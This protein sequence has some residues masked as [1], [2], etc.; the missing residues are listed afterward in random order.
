[1]GSKIFEK[2]Q[3]SKN[4]S[5]LIFNK[6]DSFIHKHD[7]LYIIIPYYCFIY[8]KENE[9]NLINF[10]EKYH[11]N[12]NAS[13]YLIEGL[14]N[15]VKSLKLSEKYDITHIKITIKDVLYVRENLINIAINN[16]PSDWNYLA[17]I[18]YNIFFTNNDWIIDTIN[19]LDLYDVVHLYENVVHFD[20]NK[21]ATHITTS[22]F[23]NTD[24]LSINDPNYCYNYAWGC[25]K[26]AYNIMEGL[27]DFDIIGNS[28]K[29]MAFSLIGKVEDSY[30]D[31]LSDEYKQKL[32]DFQDRCSNLISV[33]TIKGTILNYFNYN[34]IN[35]KKLIEGSIILIDNKYSPN[36]DITY[37]KHNLIHLTSSGKRFAKN[38]EK[39]FIQNTVDNEIE[40]DVISDELTNKIMEI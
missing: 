33:S 32:L 1:M 22:L 29:K 40:N 10:I 17:W 13:I 31:K 21:V 5:F 12:K 24:K 23:K 4:T 28:E 16:L 6:T 7:K 3:S 15:G 27:I 11:S 30:N 2:L 25:T 38:I 20:K 36:K 19:I 39:Y 18:D 8:N 34:A 26:K 37:N 9:N 14:Y 35:S